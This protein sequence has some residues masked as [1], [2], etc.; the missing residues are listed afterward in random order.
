MSI[1]LRLYACSGFLCLFFF[2]QAE[3]GIRADLVTGVQTCALP[4]SRS[5]AGKAG[6]PIGLRPHRAGDLG[7]IVHRHGVLYAAEH[8]WD[9][10]F[11][12]LVADIAA[13]FLREHDEIGRAS[14]RERV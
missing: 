3:D 9:A 1:Q 14:C 10:T 13:K 8:G 12:G 4:I 11:E 7:W 5:P 6:A 2:L